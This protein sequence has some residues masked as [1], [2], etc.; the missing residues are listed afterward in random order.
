MSVAVRTPECFPM[1]DPAILL[2]GA[3]L[4]MPN[5]ER[6]PGGHHIPGVLGGWHCPCPCHQFSAAPTHA[7]DAPVRGDGADPPAVPVTPTGDVKETT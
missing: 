1:V 2:F 4:Q 5:H 6:C 7:V 3:S